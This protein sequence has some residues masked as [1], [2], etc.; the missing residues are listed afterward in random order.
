[1]VVLARAGH[2]AVLCLSC[3]FSRSGIRCR[4]TTRAALAG[5]KVRSALGG[6]V[7]RDGVWSSEALL[8]RGKT[9]W[10]E[11]RAWY[12][13][14]TRGKWCTAG[15]AAPRETRLLEGGRG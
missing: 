2:R 15:F 13:Y 8:G 9:R 6:A 7:R 14:D 11:S 10:R 5:R 4:L 3:L 1:M 12:I